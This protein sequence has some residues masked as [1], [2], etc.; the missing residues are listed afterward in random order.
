MPSRGVCPHNSLVS[1]AP[2]SYEP[3]I[4]SWENSGPEKMPRVI[5]QEWLWQTKGKPKQQ[6]T[7]PTRV[8]TLVCTG[9]LRDLSH[10]VTAKGADKLHIDSSFAVQLPQAFIPL[11]YSFYKSAYLFQ[12]LVAIKQQAVEL[13]NVTTSTRCSQDMSVNTLWARHPSLHYWGSLR[14]PWKHVATAHQP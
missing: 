11:N 5:T 6:D 10:I 12:P 7:A 1:A 4:R 9:L 8:V 2:A 3:F 13:A 14:D